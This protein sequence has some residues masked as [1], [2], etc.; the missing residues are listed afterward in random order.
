MAS[1]P[2]MRL[3]TKLNILIFLYSFVVIAEAT[4][5]EFF[6]D[7]DASSGGDGSVSRPWDAVSDV[8]GHAFSSGDDVYFKCGCT[9]TG[10]ALNVNWSG[11][12]ESNRTIVGAYHGNGI[13]GVQGLRPHINGGLNIGGA[14]WTSKAPSTV[15]QYIGLITV[16]G[17]FVT[18]QDFDL[19]DSG[20]VGIRV[21][22]DNA[23]I[24]RNLVRV[25]YHGGIQV[26]EANDVHLLINDV[27]FR[28]M[29]RLKG[30]GYPG[31]VAYMADA[32]GTAGCKRGYAAFNRIYQSHGEG[33]D[34]GKA[35]QDSIAEF[36]TISNTRSGSMYMDR[37]VKKNTF[38]FNLI[39]CAT[40]PSVTKDGKTIWDSYDECPGGVGV[41][42]E[43]PEWGYSE[44]D[45]FYGNLIVAQKVGI[46][47]GRQVGGC[48]PPL[49][50]NNGGSCD[51]GDRGTIKVFNNTV[52]NSRIYNILVSS[53][54]TWHEPS[55]IRN[56]I[57]VCDY[58]TTGTCSSA[59]SITP[60]YG[61]NL[62]WSHNFWNG[63]TKDGD[64][65]GTGDMSGNV[66]LAKSSGWTKAA[67]IP[68]SLTGQEFALL[69]AS[70]A[71]NNG[72]VLAAS[73]TPSADFSKVLDLNRSNY[74]TGTGVDG[75]GS[76]S[77][78]FADQDANDA[79]EIGVDVHVSGGGTQIPAAPD[80]LSIR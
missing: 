76:A 39:Y 51:A 41:G 37:G 34:F 70:P 26:F 43:H 56:N 65:T 15:G 24:R 58:G 36:N 75:N 31:A 74:I 44:D 3:H 52:V 29:G 30:Q 49:G 32:P 57:F 40:R 1:N 21:V 64:S 48:P 80:G 71:V 4:A 54:I 7:C 16:S 78:V 55:E 63:G 38:R 62:T 42:D 2:G 69:Q 68:N 13:V 47:L 22:G 12:S 46:T 60:N 53:G 25:T 61:S 50:T 45:L 19:Q 5:A 27:S 35:T 77:F 23:L 33:L 72:V 10:T 59:N 17:S 20:G 18:V 9:W 79:W 14:V 66:Q 73:A 6:V 11:Q 28:G 67:I 8:T